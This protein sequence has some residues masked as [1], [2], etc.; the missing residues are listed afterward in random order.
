MAAAIVAMLLT[1]LP[2]TKSIAPPIHGSRRFLLGGS[3]QPSSS[4][5][6]R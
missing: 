4:R 3:I 1:V 5:S 2:F 6:S